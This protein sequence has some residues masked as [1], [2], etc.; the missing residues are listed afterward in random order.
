MHVLTTTRGF[1]AIA[2]GVMLVVFGVLIA[3]Q[4]PDAPGSLANTLTFSQCERACFLGIIPGVTPPEVA[5]ATLDAANLDYELIRQILF[6]T[7]TNPTEFTYT[8]IQRNNRKQIFAYDIFSAVVVVQLGT[9]TEIRLNQVRDLPVADVVTAL[10]Q[11]DRL[12]GAPL[13]CIMAYDDLG[14]LFMFDGAYLEGGVNQIVMWS[15]E[16]Q[17]SVYAGGGFGHSPQECGEAP[18]VVQEME[19]EQTV[20]SVNTTSDVATPQYE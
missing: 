5:A 11:P 3:A 16:L 8:L 20:S 1:L 12:I 13:G 14:L 15:A 4:R 2:T 6:D 9:I 7:S 17:A 10:G 18:A 19:A